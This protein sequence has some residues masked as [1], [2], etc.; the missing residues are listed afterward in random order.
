MI[1]TKMRRITVISAGKMIK[2]Q[3]ISVFVGAKTFSEPIVNPANMGGERPISVVSGRSRSQKKR[4]K[5]TISVPQKA[6]LDELH[7]KKNTKRVASRQM[8]MWR[9]KIN[10]L[11]TGSKHI[12]LGR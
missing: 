3:T 7:A 6:S 9:L 8:M 4:K 5:R 1:R 11:I 10:M 2:S 12:W